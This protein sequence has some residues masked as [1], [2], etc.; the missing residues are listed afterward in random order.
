M[1][2]FK[3]HLGIWSSFTDVE[4]WICFCCISLLVSALGNRGAALSSVNGARYREQRL[5]EL[6]HWTAA[7]PTLDTEFQMWYLT[8]PLLSFKIV[9]PECRLVP[10]SWCY[11]FLGKS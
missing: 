6:E 8:R 10:V 2:N 11:V 5:S 7:K 3:I 1:R 4:P 9:P